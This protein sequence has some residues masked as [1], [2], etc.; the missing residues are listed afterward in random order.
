MN[1]ELQDLINDIK[2]WTS[3]RSYDNYD[4]NE[5]DDDDLSVDYNIVPYA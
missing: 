2:S 3:I 4:I 5:E 1:I